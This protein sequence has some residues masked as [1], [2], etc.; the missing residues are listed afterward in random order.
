[1]EIV[2]SKFCLEPEEEPR[3]YRVGFTVIPQNNREFYRDALVRFDDPEERAEEEVVNDAWERLKERIE[4]RV[5][6]L[7]QEPDVLGKR[8][9][10]DKET[11]RLQAKEDEKEPEEDE[12]KSKED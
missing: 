2:V 5:E 7:E 8:F 10:R 11:G 6:A 1:M 9:E 4:R 12:E 3:G